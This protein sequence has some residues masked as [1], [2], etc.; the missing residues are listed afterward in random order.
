MQ[1]SEF[2]LQLNQKLEPT[3]YAKHDT[4]KKR[5]RPLS[6]NATLCYRPNSTHQYLTTTELKDASQEEMDVKLGK[7]TRTTYVCCD[8]T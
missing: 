3:F 1:S 8:L 6:A 2:S 7:P 5:R 4:D